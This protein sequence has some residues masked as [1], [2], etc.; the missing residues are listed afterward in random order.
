MTT[1]REMHII[2]LHDFKPAMGIFREE[3]LAGLRKQQKEICPKYFYDETGSG[4]FEQICTLDEYYIPR[5]E[6]SIMEKNI[7]EIVGVLGPDVLLVEYGCGDCKKTQILINR[8]HDMSAYIPIDISCEQLMTVSRR[9]GSEYPGLEILP[10]CADFTNDFS[11]PDGKRKNDRVVV[12][13]PGSS[14][15]NLH[16][17]QARNLLQQIARLCGPGGALLIGVDLKKDSSVLHRAY[18]DRHN[19]TSAFNLNIL[20]RL[21]R[22]LS[23]DFDLRSFEHYAFYNPVKGRIEMHLISLKDQVVQLDDTAINFARG[24]SIWTES[25]YKYNL[26]EFKELAVASG[27]TVDRVW[28]D[29]QR[30]FSIQYLVAAADNFKFDCN[31]ELCLSRA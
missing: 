23:A 9:L 10:V 18:N 1:T 5:T 31:M 2:R 27:F 11:L 24:E 4:L 19:V 16:P 25:S 21:N 8:M 12:Y 3:V 20:E 14:I 29:E 17:E 26:N 6:I 28:T 22:E 7:D 13:F 15:G 30:W